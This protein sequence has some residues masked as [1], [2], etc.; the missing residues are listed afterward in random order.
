MDKKEQKWD[1]GLTII[2][3][4]NFLKAHHC[5]H[6]IYGKS[7]D[8]KSIQPLSP[9][10]VGRLF[11]KYGC[12]DVYRHS[13]NGFYPQQDL[14]L[15]QMWRFYVLENIEKFSI[16]GKAQLL[17]S[18]NFQIRQNGDRRNEELKRLFIKHKRK[19]RTY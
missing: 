3:F 15:S 2:L 1:N 19:L 6:R 8:L 16:K 12:D 5:M 10:Q 4:V 9:S 14:I 13:H 18:L 7:C 11:L 17:E